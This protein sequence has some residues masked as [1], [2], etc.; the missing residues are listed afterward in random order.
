MSKK[1]KNKIEMEEKSLKWEKEMQGERK[2]KTLKGIMEKKT[3]KYE[4][5]E[6]HEKPKKQLRRRKMWQR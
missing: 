2:G 4:K 5:Y 6:K 1:M 3:R